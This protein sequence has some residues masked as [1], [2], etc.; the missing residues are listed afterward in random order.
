M[1]QGF[2]GILRW[3]PAQRMYF[4]PQAQEL[5]D[6][7]IGSEPGNEVKNGRQGFHASYVSRRTNTPSR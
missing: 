2:G 6:P 4:T 1:W 7:L 3:Q 5:K